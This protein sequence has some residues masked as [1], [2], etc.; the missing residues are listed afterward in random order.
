MTR[1]DAALVVE[2]YSDLT[3]A[4]RWTASMLVSGLAAQNTEAM[5]KKIKAFYPVTIDIDGDPVT[6]HIRRMST[7]DIQAFEE[8]M[9]EFGYSFDGTKVVP[10]KPVNG[11]ELAAWL[12]KTIAENISI[13]PDQLAIEGP[14]GADV[15]MTTGAEL[16]A[17]FGGRVDFVPTLIA[18]IWGENRM[19]EKRKEE[20]RSVAEKAVAEATGNAPIAVDIPE[21]ELPVT[22]VDPPQELPPPPDQPSLLQ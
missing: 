4:V 7:V 14:D 18:Y 2:W 20:F 11:K 17:Q 6:L 8:S 19:P 5:M 15:P 21:P 12:M 16:I 13:P 9:R 3:D 22:F 10:S 1:E